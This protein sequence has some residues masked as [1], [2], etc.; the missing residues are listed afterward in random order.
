MFFGTELHLTTMKETTDDDVTNH[1]QMYDPL[2]HN[3]NSESKHIK[4]SIEQLC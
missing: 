3:T 2:T 1:A 4:L